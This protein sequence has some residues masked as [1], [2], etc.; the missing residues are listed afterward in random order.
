MLSTAHKIK[1]VHHK[2]R[3]SVKRRRRGQA[4]IE[5]ALVI[6]VLLAVLIG[7]M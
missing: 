6:P 1:V 5:F 2:R 7:I 4:I 3:P